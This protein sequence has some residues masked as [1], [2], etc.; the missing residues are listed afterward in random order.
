MTAMPNTTSQSYRWRLAALAL[1]MLLP[2]LG[3]SIANVAL[4]TLQS[5]FAASSQDVQWVVIA[6]LLAVTSLI[7]AAGRLGDLFGRR[8]LLL[9]GIGIFTLASAAGAM[10]PSLLTLVTAR[11]VQGAGAAIMMA[12]AVA[13]VGD[14]IPGDRTGS[15]MGLLGTVSAVGT[16]LGPSLGGVLIAW[17]GWSAVFA[18]TALAGAVALPVALRT[19]PRYRAGRQGAPT[20]DVAGVILLALSLAAYAL[21]TTVDASAAV[22][23]ALAVGAA[24]GVVAFGLV[25]ARV[26]SPLIQLRLLRDAELSSGLITLGLVSAIVMATLVVGPLY[27]SGTLTQSALQTG[28][29]MTVGPGVA[30][31]T[32]VPAG[33]LVDRLGASAVTKGGL[34]GI[35]LGSVLMTWLPGTYG[36][37]GY[38]ASL[39]LIAASYALFQAANNTAVMRTATADRRGVT[40]A[41]LALARNLGLVTGASLMGALFAWGSRGAVGFELAGGGEAGLQLTFAVAA[42]LGGLALATALYG[43]RQRAPVRFGENLQQLDLTEPVGRAED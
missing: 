25:E 20:L 6:Y 39:A 19:L 23:L 40:S 1:V 31:L 38:V 42:A 5:S 16:A 7:V 30:A 9:A 26:A 10:A 41:L 12:L 37:A 43:S 36:V 32:G 21:S 28:L 34:A 22:R 35:I 11:G 24:A 15:A 33:R 8:R 3:T 17:W 27:L 18:V 29:V 2:S 4:P 14:T 13:M